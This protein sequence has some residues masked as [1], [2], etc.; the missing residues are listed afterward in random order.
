MV[1]GSRGWG[2]IDLHGDIK[3]VAL[4]EKEILQT[5]QSM[6]AEAAQ[7]PGETF[8]RHQRATLVLLP[9]QTLRRRPNED[10][11]P[12]RAMPTR[13]DAADCRND[14]GLDESARTFIP[15]TAKAKEMRGDVPIRV[16]ERRGD[17]IRVILPRHDL[18]VYHCFDGAMVPWESSPAGWALAARPG[19]AK[20]TKVMLW[21]ETSLG[22]GP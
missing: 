12:A 15:R 20:G 8:T 17:W 16:A 22:P 3:R 4:R 9:R 5:L 10:A 1:F 21:H 13:L 18:P 11:P 14:G 7:R 2:W 19:P 6:E